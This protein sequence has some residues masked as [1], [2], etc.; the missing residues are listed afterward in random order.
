MTIQDCQFKVVGYI[1]ETGLGGML[2]VKDASLQIKGYYDPQANRTMD[3]SF[4][5]AKVAARGNRPVPDIRACLGGRRMLSS[6][7]ALA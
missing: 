5:T 7:T 3:S 2:V 4:R 6:V 1:E